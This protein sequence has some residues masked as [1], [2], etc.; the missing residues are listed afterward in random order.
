MALHARYNSEK[1]TACL[2]NA[3]TLQHKWRISLDYS[4]ANNLVP[5]LE[6]TF[7]LVHS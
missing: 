4:D 3:V 6:V 1:Q 5:L 7:R 2:M